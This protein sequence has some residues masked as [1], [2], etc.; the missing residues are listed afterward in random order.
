MDR[1]LFTITLI[2]F[3]NVL[4]SGLILPLLP[5]FAEA[6]GANAVV[7]GLFI[8]TYP[9]FS[10]LAGPPLGVLSDKYGRKPILIL[11]IIGSIIGFILLGVAT[12]LPLLF[13]SRIIDG[14][15]AGNMSTAKAAIADITT[16]EERTTKLGFTFAAESLGLILGPVLGG[17]FA[18]YG[19]TVSAYIAAGISVVCLLLTIFFFDET[20]I[21]TTQAEQQENSN[22]SKPGDW[23]RVIRSPRTRNYV[24]IVFLIQLLIMMMWGTLALSVKARY[25]FGG[26]ELG[27]ISAFAALTGILSQTLLLKVLTSRITEKA[28][29]VMALFV[30]CVGQ[31]LLAFDFSVL[32]MLIGV[33]LMA[34][35]FNVGMPTV[36][37]MVSKLSDEH[38]QGSV[39]GTT[40]SAVGLGMVIGPIFA[41]S[42]FSISIQG[43]YLI[44]SG[45]GLLAT[46]FSLSQIP[47]KP[48]ASPHTPL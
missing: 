37:G 8:S 41:T 48:Q 23:L 33:G 22:A 5:F 31:L 3:V 18:Q 34:A 24:L 35:S 17:M 42:L 47:A 32:V 15:S 13:I 11:S 20:K 44:A 12:S 10:I 45:L 38:E 2:I 6:M 40:N 7:V 39:M 46:L 21:A 26:T 36:I 28:I 9:L 27:Y 14:I 1:R 25:G 30:M 19:F 43:S 29:I 16:R 4:G